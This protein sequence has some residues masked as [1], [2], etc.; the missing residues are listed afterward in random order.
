MAKTI[1]KEIALKLRAKGESVNV[2]ARKVGVS[3]STASLWVKD[4]I[5]TIEQLESLRQNSIKG[6]ERGRIKGAFMQ[7]Q[8]RIL[9]PASL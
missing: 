2:I 5:L 9:P 7:K 6:S 8:R 1:Q 4:V 3:K